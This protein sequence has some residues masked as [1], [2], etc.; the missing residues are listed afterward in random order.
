MVKEVQ[1]DKDE[2]V[3]SSYSADT[4]DSYCADGQDIYCAD[5]Q[6][7]YCADAQGHYGE[8][9]GRYAPEVLMPAL[10]ELEAC[11]EEAKA[12]PTFFAELEKAEKEFTGRPTPLYFCE[13]LSAHLG[14]AQIFVKNEGLAHTGAH[15]I[16]HCIGQAL[17]AKRMGKKRII[18]ETGAG[19][20]GLA[21]ATVCAKFGLE[22]VV[23][24]GALDVA[25]QRPNVFWMEKLG[26]T[27]VPVEYGGKRL[28]DAVNAALKEWITRVEDS[29]YLLGS[30]VG[31]HPFPE[32][33]RFF[34][35]VVSREIK[36]QM[37]AHCQD[38]P[39]HVIACVGGGS[40]AAGAFDAFLNE[41]QVTLIGVEAGGKGERLGEHA[42]RLASSATEASSTTKDDAE[43][44][45]SAG[46]TIGVVEGF[47]SYWLQD[48]HGQIAN[49]H[50]ISAGL[51]Y[52]GVGPLHAHL[53][54]I[55][56]VH[57][58]FARDAQVLEAFSLL[59][60]HEGILSALESAHALAE[61]IRLAPL[62]SSDKRIVVN[63]SGRGDKDI[64]IFARHL[65]DDTFF[66]FL[67]NYVQ[68]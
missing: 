17:L 38:L 46:G 11:F 9:G 13:N 48:T 44:R 1:R 66:E 30:C 24:M 50:S 6:D 43:G 20:H 56:R 19:Q 54:N 65:G 40:N 52:A 15:K 4:Q 22:C 32:I 59:A 8:F 28:K 64:F 62:L 37:Y 60:K 18:A 39:T 47:K 25:R 5:A 55:G 35:S 68:E 21:T 3:D 23:Y 26:A 7:I 10:L 67:R 33:N 27:V 45:K 2:V 49:T 36:E 16:N 34:Q 42:V 29:H 57:Y 51:D 61:G 14:G 58:T 41:A 53:H 31:P 63:L 12:D